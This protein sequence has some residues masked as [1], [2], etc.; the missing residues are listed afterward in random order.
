MANTWIEGLLRGRNDGSRAWLA[1][2]GHPGIRPAMRPPVTSATL[3]HRQ[4][5]KVGCPEE[6][7]WRLGGLMDDQ[8]ETFGPNPIL[9][10]KRLR[11][12]ILLRR[13]VDGMDSVL[14]TAAIKGAAL[15]EAKDLRGS[16]GHLAHTQ[17][18]RRCR[19]FFLRRAGM[20]A[21]L[22]R[23]L[24]VSE[25]E[26]PIFHAGQPTPA[27]G[28]GACVVFP[29][30]NCARTTRQAGCAA[31]PANF[32]CRSTSGP[33]RPLSGSGL[34]ERLSAEKPPLLWIH[35]ALPM[36]FSPSAPQRRS[37]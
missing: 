30:I 3:E 20:R 29:T 17:G 19:G 10:K 27:R 5:L 32:Y 18:I 28:Q 1:G 16:Q 23:A 37:L 6:V 31:S 11:Q 4:G 2:Y 26:A 35:P 34:G 9:K 14:T 15:M 8:L 25:A 21:V 36:V 22:L 7:G 24:G 13:S 12:T 33:A